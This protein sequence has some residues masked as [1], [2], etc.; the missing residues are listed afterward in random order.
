VSQASSTFKYLAISGMI[1]PPIPFSPPKVGVRTIKF[2]GLPPLSVQPNPTPLFLGFVG[3]LAFLVCG[4]LVYCVSLFVL[5]FS[6]LVRC[7]WVGVGVV[8]VL[9]FRLPLGPSFS[10]VFLGFLVG[11]LFGFGGGWSLRGVFGLFILVFGGFFGGVGG[12]GGV[13]FGGCLVGFLLV[14]SPGFFSVFFFFVFWGVCVGGFWGFFVLFPWFFLCFLF[15]G[16]GGCVGGF[17]GG[18]L[19]SVPSSS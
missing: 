1:Q 16:F 10:S 13:F 15:M 9:C 19:G 11:F 17:V 4:S 2:F 12:G 8:F 14:G 18:F 5:G 7:V 3:V 6:L